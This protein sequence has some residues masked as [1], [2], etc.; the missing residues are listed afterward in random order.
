MQFPNTLV[1]PYPKINALS[2]WHHFHSYSSLTA[3]FV[4]YLNFLLLFLKS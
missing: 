3:V 2:H 4:P 1:F